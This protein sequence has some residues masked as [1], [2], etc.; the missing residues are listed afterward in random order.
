MDSLPDL[1]IAGVAGISGRLKAISA[2]LKEGDPPVAT[3]SIAAE[4][5]I[6]VQTFRRMP[7]GNPKIGFQ[8]YQI[9]LQSVR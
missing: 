3:G 1:G 5:P 6:E 7:C 2:N 8:R 4:G 9:R